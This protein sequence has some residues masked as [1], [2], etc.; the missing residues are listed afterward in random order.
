M[1]KKNFRRSPSAIIGSIDVSRSTRG[2]AVD[3]AN[4]LVFVAVDGDPSKGIPHT[5]AIIN[6]K[7]RNVMSSVP[8]PE[9]AAA[10][11]GVAYDANDRRVYVAIPNLGVGVIDPSKGQDGYVTTIQILGEK[12]A[13]GTY[14]VAVDERARLVYATNRADSSFS[15][16][17]PAGLKELD[18][19][20]VGKLPEGLGV[21]GDRGVTYVG[22]SG[23]NTISFISAD[24]KT[25]RYTVFATLI[26]GPTPKAAAVDSGAG[27]VYVPTFADDAVRVIQP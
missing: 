18:R 6:A 16:I 7:D 13:A 15:V 3:E 9:G 26:V 27:R 5:V 10:G 2:V 1:P 22:N 14:G 17:D 11:I 19:V 12:G 21:D 25:G 4:D 20:R 24:S 23:E 8:L